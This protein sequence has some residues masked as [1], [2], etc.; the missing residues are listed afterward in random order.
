[1]TDIRFDTCKCGA[2]IV[3]SATAVA[4]LKNENK[5]LRSDIARLER[6]KSSAVLKWMAASGECAAN[7][8]KLREALKEVSKLRKALGKVAIGKGDPRF[9]ACA[10]L[11]GDND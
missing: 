2:V 1:M 9:I 11:G 5:K 10:A 4:E 8:G 7:S 3:S 6:E